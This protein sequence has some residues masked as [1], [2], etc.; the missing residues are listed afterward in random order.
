MVETQRPKHAY[1]A[2]RDM[3]LSQ[4]QLIDG[5]LAVCQTW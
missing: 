2:V 3:P 5:V 4:L 1:E